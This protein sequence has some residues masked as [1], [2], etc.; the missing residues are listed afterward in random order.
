MA[1][2]R[3]TV[4]V[5][6]I[7][8]ILG[9]QVALFESAERALTFQYG[10]IDY[11][12]DILPFGQTDYYRAEF[13]EDLSRV[14]VSFT[15]LID[16]GDL[17]D[18][19]RSTN[20]L[21]RCWSQES[22]RRMNLDPGY[23]TLAKLVLAT[24]KDRAHRVYLNRGIYGEATLAYRD[25]GFVPWPWTY[26]DYASAPYCEIMGTIRAQYVRQLAQWRESSC[27]GHDRGDEESARVG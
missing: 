23:I 9:G 18:I 3:K 12:S 10:P 22:R 25:G 13:G 2:V 5:K 27:P 19:K 17:P 21:E 6:L 16:P 1:E 8:S 7:V 11:R 4:P 14:F 24:T 15:R 26:P 20:A